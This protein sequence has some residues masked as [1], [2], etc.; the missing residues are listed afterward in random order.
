MSAEQELLGIIREIELVE[1]DIRDRNTAK[2]AIYKAAA[3]KGY[4]KKV[5]RKVVAARRLD[6][7]VRNEQDDVFDTYMHAIE[8]AEKGLVSARVENIDKNPLKTSNS[9]AQAKLVETVAAGLQT[10]AGRKALVAAVDIMI[11]REEQ[12]DPDTGEITN[13]EAKASE[14]NGTHKPQDGEGVTGDASRPVAGRLATA[15][16]EITDETGGES[17]A[18]NSE[19]TPDPQ[20]P[21]VDDGQPHTSSSPGSA[22][23]DA[24]SSIVGQG[25][26]SG[27]NHTGS[28]EEQAVTNFEPPAFIREAAKLRPDCLKPD[29]CAGYG[30]HQCH[31]CTK[32]A[33]EVAA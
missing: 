28:E 23:S 17:A 18:T 10:E 19:I 8:R 31:A 14:D 22:K 27:C 15:T 21:L 11:E 30:S 4:D 1:E 20:P 3:E 2:S 6:P 12:I 26:D 13:P 33:R 16:S 24:L 7:T 9:Y 29:A 32:A 25:R 5:I